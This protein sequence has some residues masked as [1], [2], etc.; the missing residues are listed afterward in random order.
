MSCF[1]LICRSRRLF[2][3][4]MQQAC[5]KIDRTRAHAGEIFAKLLYHRL[6]RAF[7]RNVTIILVVIVFSCF[8]LCA[9]CCTSDFTL[10]V[11]CSPEIPNIPHK[12]EVQSA[13]PREK[14]EYLNWASSSDTFPKF[15]LLLSCPT[16]IYHIVLGLT[17]S[18]G[19]LTESLVSSV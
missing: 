5:E 16:Y 6:L 18:A 12:A 14:L 10:F 13:F 7:V 19:G 9:R 17:V 4:L 2:C 8:H 1:M 3:E 15:A 11:H